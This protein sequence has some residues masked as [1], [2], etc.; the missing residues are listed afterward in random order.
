[1]SRPLRHP[2]ELNE[3]QRFLQARRIL[4]S[5]SRAKNPD[6]HKNALDLNHQLHIRYDGESV[7]AWLHHVAENRWDPGHDI[8]EAIFTTPEAT[9]I[10]LKGIFDSVLPKNAKSLG[11]ILHIADE[12]ATTEIKPVHGDP[13]ELPNLRET[14]IEDPFAVIDDASLSIDEHVWR[15]FP[16]GGK[17]AQSIA[18]AITL[19]RRC[20]HFLD[21]CRRAGEERD[22]PVRTLALSAPL[23]MLQNLPFLYEGE[24]DRPLVPILHYPDQRLPT[25][26][27]HTISV[28]ATALEFSDP[29]LLLLPLADPQSCTLLAQRIGKAFPPM[30]LRL[31]VGTKTPFAPE[32]TGCERA[33]CFPNRS[34]MRLLRFASFA[35]FGF[36]AAALALLAW[37]GLSVL[38][39]IRKPEWSF[40]PSQSTVLRGRIMAMELKNKQIEQWDNLLDDR[41][42]GWADME[43]LARLFPP[44]SGLLLIGAR[45][46]TKPDGAPVAGKAGFVKEWRLS[47]FADDK[48]L[49]RLTKLNTQQGI[50]TAFAELVQATGN[51]AFD[52]APETRT[53]IVDMRP[54]E[55]PGFRQR[56][57]GEGSDSDPSTYPF[58]F[59]LAIVQ[60][61][62]AT[63]PMAISTAKAPE[64]D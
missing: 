27:V 46:I 54:R 43:M 17:S 64:L 3:L 53:L 57:P 14:I 42:R 21:F 62:D 44:D 35:R 15:L 7:R 33:E 24:L 6:W 11:I 39:T 22:F 8:P 9:A 13:L 28:T 49:R 31:V 51:T 59:D 36:I 55:N 34:E 50:E 19:S 48:G 23:V 45:H 40:D 41:S 25:N 38:Q 29:L 47:G 30:E 2:S 16:Y 61:F 4:R 10:F 5:T 52:P 63:D 20:E 12:F 60:R 26:L 56:P 1:V 37:T 32:V 58:A 18:T